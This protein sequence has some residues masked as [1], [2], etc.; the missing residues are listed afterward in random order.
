MARYLARVRTELDRGGVDS[1]VCNDMTAPWGEF[2]GPA[3][4]GFCTAVVGQV[5]QLVDETLRE[6]GVEVAASPVTLSDGAVFD[7]NR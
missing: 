3:R 1:L 6:H 4:H 5:A 2:T 7:P